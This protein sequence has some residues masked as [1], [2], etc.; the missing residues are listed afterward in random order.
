MAR[1]IKQD[2]LKPNEVDLLKLIREQPDLH[3]QLVEYLQEDER[4]V[5]KKK[6]NLVEVDSQ[7]FMII[8]TDVL[9]LVHDKIGEADYKKLIGLGV[10]LKTR[11]NILFNHTKPFTLESLS[12]QLNIN[13]ENTTKFVQRMVKQGIMA[14]TVCAPSGYVEK[15]YAMNPLL[16]RRGKQY[17]EVFLNMY[18]RDFTKELKG[19]KK[20]DDME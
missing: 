2:R 5:I 6:S 9:D 15:I 11:Y 7:N 8:D 19:G 1:Q 20:K 13:K 18:F 10:F 3:Q 14:Y 12:K 17:D 4:I 16:I